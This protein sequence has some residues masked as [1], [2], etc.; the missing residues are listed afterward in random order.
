M[1]KIIILLVCI[2]LMGCTN[3]ENGKTGQ[4]LETD[5]ES[6]PTVT[7]LD[8]KTFKV[9]RQVELENS[10]IVGHEISYHVDG[11]NI[12]GFEVRPSSIEGLKYPLLIYNRGGNNGFAQISDKTVSFLLAK[13]AEEDFVVLASQYRGSHTE[14]KDEFGG[15]DLND[16]NRLIEMAYDLAYVDTDRIYMLGASRGSVM[17]LQLL[18]NRDD[19]RAA[20][21]IGT[22][23]N[24]E[25]LYYEREDAMKSVL[26]DCIGGTPEALIKEYENRSAVYWADEVEA[27]LLLLHGGNDRSVPPLQAITL[28][29]KLDVFG[30]TSKLIVYE[31]DS[32]ILEENIND[33]IK[34]IIEW[35]KSH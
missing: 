27:P 19:I 32:H 17:T 34:E 22:V 29:E 3:N 13:F 23:S 20:A 15:Q 10:E 14:G 24:V 31:N 11:L 12:T 16:I 26:V 30:K 2:F 1:K 4:P 7:S 9:I 21:T 6:P 35:F 25:S 33:A 8:K 18:R 5:Q 28:K